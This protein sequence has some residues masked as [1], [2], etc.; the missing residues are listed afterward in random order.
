MERISSMGLDME[1][2]VGKEKDFSLSVGIR[3]TSACIPYD[4]IYLKNK[5]NDPDNHEMSVDSTGQYVRIKIEATPGS[6][7]GHSLKHVQ[8]SARGV[9]SH[10]Q[11]QKLSGNNPSLISLHKTDEDLSLSVT[12]FGSNIRNSP[13]YWSHKDKVIE[14]I[15]ASCTIS[16]Q[17]LC[18]INFYAICQVANVEVDNNRVVELPDQVQNYCLL[19]LC[20]L[21]FGGRGL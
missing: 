10:K 3:K 2:S 12:I 6:L 1:K 16:C 4:S 11:Y 20:Y 15:V 17:L 8:F 9:K 5:N 18:K 13:L 21:F 19:N 7:T 14:D